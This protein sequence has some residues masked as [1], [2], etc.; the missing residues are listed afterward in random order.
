MGTQTR[1]PITVAQ[2]VKRT[3]H[4]GD[5]CPICKDWFRGNNCSHSIAQAEAKLDE[6]VIRAIVRDELE[7]GS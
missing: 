4:P 3:W 2:Q 7:N 6:N 5:K 1:N